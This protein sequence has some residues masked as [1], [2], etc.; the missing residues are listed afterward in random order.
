MQA[1]LT[2]H[3]VLCLQG[4]SPE[5]P[6]PSSHLPPSTAPNYLSVCPLNPPKRCHS[7][8][9]LAEL[10]SK[11]DS[12]ESSISPKLRKGLIASRPRSLNLSMSNLSAV[13][14]SVLE[15]NTQVQK[16]IKLESRHIRSSSDI[17]KITE[18]RE[19]DDKPH[20]T[21]TYG[22]KIGSSELQSE[23]LDARVKLS[24]LTAS[25]PSLTTAASEKS[26]AD[27][28]STDP[29]LYNAQSGKSNI[30][31]AYT[32]PSDLNKA[33]SVKWSKEKSR[34][35]SR[36]M[37]NLASP[38]SDCSSELCMKCG[39]VDKRSVCHGVSHHVDISKLN[40]SRS[41]HSSTEMIP[42]S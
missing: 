36:S 16:S 20:A 32:A 1:H 30:T 15:L 31:S 33:I 22:L 12:P 19:T 6:T 7:W 3:Y 21:S 8:N 27:C 40:Q 17:V 29:Q 24:E 42:V 13:P 34:R 35:R 14:Q 4:S 18:E 5:T 10:A 2:V 23:N 11:C 26:S 9:G 28:N 39:R 41:L 25:Q 38:D 37:E